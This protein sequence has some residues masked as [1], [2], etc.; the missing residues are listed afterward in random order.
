MLLSFRFGN[1]RS[2]LTEQIFSMEAEGLKNYKNCLLT[3]GSDKYLPVAAVYGKN[4][5]GKSNL[6]RAMW[7]G[8]QF[9]RNSQRTQTPGA[10]V[11]VRPF[12]LD[13]TS[14]KEPTTFEYTY[15]SDG[16]KY[17]YGFS[18]TRDR[19]VEEHLYHWPK[20]TKA[21]IFERTEQDVKS[22]KDNQKKTKDT[23]M[24]FVA[25]NQLYLV[26]ASAFNYQPCIKAMQWFLE[27]PVFLR[28]YPDFPQQLTGYAED[29]AMLEAIKE[30]AKEADTGVADM[31]FEFENKE[32]DQAAALPD[33]MP[34]DLRRALQSFMAALAD[35]ASENK[36]TL[37]FNQVKATTFHYGI[38]QNGERKLYPLGLDDE[39]GGTLQMMAMAS[40]IG[41]A[42]STGGILIV[43]ELE[44]KLHPLLVRFIVLKFQ[45]PATNKNGAQLIFTTHTTELLDMDILRRDQIYF[46]DK[47]RTS[48][49]SELY[50]ILDL[51][52]RTDESIHKRYLLGKYGAV[53]LLD[54]VDLDEEA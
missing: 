33:D 7:L 16:I 10:S 18:A 27:Q 11:P 26:V 17:C 36:G 53:P 50:S 46:V 6:I 24:G 41:K 21:K 19:I 34:D 48:G 45:S 30:M 43:D 54:D 3:F 15:V 12:L 31:R 1:Y 38:V 52:T 35:P 44:A 28:D 9:V 49:A 42:L 23:I 2:F 14:A 37:T 47:N 20:G 40:A 13:D 22:P 25:P 29:E 51:G 32:I 4:G 39:S 5:G 8:V